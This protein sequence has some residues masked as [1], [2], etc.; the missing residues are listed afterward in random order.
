VRQ[1]VYALPPVLEA[2]IALGAFMMI[3]SMYFFGTRNARI[4]VLMSTTV[5]ALLA[6][7]LLLVLL[8]EH[9]FA[10]KVAVKST[11]FRQGV[12]SQFWS[13]APS[14]TTP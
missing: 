1:A 6:F 7:N 4:H 11:P 5:A 12:L 13:D 10:G 14:T 2:L 9:P 3:G 8:L